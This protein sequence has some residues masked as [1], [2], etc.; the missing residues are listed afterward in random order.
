M[1][2]T[3]ILN[4]ENKSYKPVLTDK[5]VYDTKPTVNSFNGITSDAVARAIAGA[6]GEVPAV[7][8]SD[9]GKVLTAVYDEGGAA[10]EWAE[11]QGGGSVTTVDKAFTVGV[12]GTGLPITVDCA[13]ATATG[14]S[15]SFTE[16]CTFTTFMNNP[17]VVFPLAH[18][19]PCSLGSGTATLT[20]PEDITYDTTGMAL[21][22]VT[23]SY[24][25]GRSPGPSCSISSS[26]LSTGKIN[27]GAY[28]ISGANTAASYFSDGIII[29]IAGSGNPTPWNN[30]IAA[31]TEAVQSWTL[32]YST[33][34]VTGYSITPT[35][36]PSGGNTG[37]VLT[38]NNMGAVVWGTV[39]NELP[40][41]TG[42]ANRVLTVNSRAYDVEWKAP[43]D[44]T[45]VYA[46]TPAGGSMAEEPWQAVQSRTRIG[47]LVPYA[48][49]SG[50]LAA[51]SLYNAGWTYLPL[52][53]I[54]DRGSG[55]YKWNFYLYDG[56]NKWSLVLTCD[57]DEWSWGT[58]T[59][60]PG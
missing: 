52:A 11:A 42:N 24:W 45:M 41:L 28:T 17:A 36:L 23:I 9:N 58:P 38:I 10:V 53:S 54:V 8:E 43:L 51:G 1:A 22:S 39:P 32:S 33:I 21:N 18:L 57:E 7:T 2:L 27:A 20:V 13:N 55:E 59:V 37:N 25:N 29:F 15:T 34:E 30:F 46:E 19:D 12:N 16:N 50:S 49:F 47:C 26:F 60:V 5:L 48:A 44:Y 56:A 3:K 4:D 40:P 31:F 14:N 6:S 35:V